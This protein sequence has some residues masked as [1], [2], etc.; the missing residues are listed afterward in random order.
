MKQ[1]INEIKRMQRLAGLINEEKAVDEGIGKALGTV[2]LGAALALGTPKDAAAQM[3]PQ[4]IEKPADIKLSNAEIGD[5]LWH[6][7]SEH[8][9]TVNASE[10]NSAVT[11][12]LSKA[13]AEATQSGYPYNAVEKLGKAAKNDLA[14]M[15]IVNTSEDT[16]RKASKDAM[17]AA[18][19]RGYGDSLEEIVNEALAKFRKTGK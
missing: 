1:S 6:A 9:S 15:A 7:Y 17:D 18:K 4:G 16:L 14:A 13:S 10:L 2:A 19:K 5:K 12:A 3:K 8:R 11:D